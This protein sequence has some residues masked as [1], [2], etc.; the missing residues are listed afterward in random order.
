M[1]TIE[2]PPIIPEAKLV[3]KKGLKR[4]KSE[5]TDELMILLGL[6]KSM[7]YCLWDCRGILLRK[8]NLL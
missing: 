5:D 1:P 7:V 2:D 3:P 4:S 8:P 6:K